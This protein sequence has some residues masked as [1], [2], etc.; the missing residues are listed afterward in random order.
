LRGSR[1]VQIEGTLTKLRVIAGAGVV[2]LFDDYHTTPQCIAENIQNTD[3][4]IANA[5]VSDR[6]RKSRTMRNAM[7]GRTYY[8]VL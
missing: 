7:T 6:R 5:G 2:F 3:E 1:P 8:P 4:L